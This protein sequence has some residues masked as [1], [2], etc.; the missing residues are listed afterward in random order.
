MN[1]LKNDQLFPHIKGVMLKDKPV[2]LTLS[3][4]ANVVQSQGNKARVE[5]FFSDHKKSAIIS[6]AQSLIIIDMYGPDCEAWAGKRVELYGEFG[7]W[8]GKDQ[9]GIRVSNKVPPAPRKNGRSD[10]VENV[11]A[12]NAFAD[13]LLAP[14]MDALLSPDAGY[15]EK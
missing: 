14:A 3:G 12:A 4:K 8:F 13:S 1:L 2:T 10:S 11:I 9:W 6:P 15:D 5:I 7:N